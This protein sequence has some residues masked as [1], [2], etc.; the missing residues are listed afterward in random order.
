MY[1]LLLFC[2]EQTVVVQL[3]CMVYEFVLVQH[4][5]VAHMRLFSVFL[6]LPSATVRL[7]AQRRMAIDDDDNKAELDD[8][9]DIAVADTIAVPGVKKNATAALDKPQKSVRVAEDVAGMG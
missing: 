8:D 2:A 5:N 4:V 1:N 9:D 3:S 6:A 7:L